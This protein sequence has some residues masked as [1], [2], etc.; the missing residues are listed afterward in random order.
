[1]LDPQSELDV[2]EKIPKEKITEFGN[3]LDERILYMRPN[4][5]EIERVL[6]DGFGLDATAKLIHVFYNFFIG[7]RNP[8]KIFKIIDTSKLDEEKKGVKKN[9]SNNSQ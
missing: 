8:D 3:L 5:S 2:F 4:P 9:S 1:M 7:K 6:G